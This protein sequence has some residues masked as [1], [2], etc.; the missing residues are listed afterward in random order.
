MP[1]S[2]RTRPMSRAERRLWRQIRAR[3]GRT[4]PGMQ[5]AIELSFDNIRDI[6]TESEIIRLLDSTRSDA[7]ITSLV[8]EL[9]A[10][11]AFDPTRVRLLADVQAATNA[12][13]LDLPGGGRVSGQSIAAF[14][15]LND[16]TREAVRQLDS[17]VMRSLIDELRE[18]MREAA[19]IGLERGEGSRTIARRVRRSIGLAPNQ[20]GHIE[21]FRAKLLTGDFKGAFS[22][23]LRDKRFDRTL[24]R[25][26]SEGGRLSP[27]QVNKMTAAYTRKWLRHNSEVHARTAMNDAQRLGRHLATVGAIENGILPAGRMF[28][29]WSSSGDSR[30]RQ[31]HDDPPTGVH[32]QVVRFGTPFA[33]GDVVPG[34]SEWGCRCIKVDFIHP[35][36]PVTEPPT[37]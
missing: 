19:R 34:A 5:R 32:G 9:E 11:R 1:E 20:L 35:G 7:F 37:L 6:L 13:M 23:R 31:T 28:S 12:F 18:T 21:R 17:R 27:D 26:I 8:D 4:T 22:N 14:N 36:N 30:V 15:L 3:V 24:R 25:L 29:R 16:R 10:N 2:W 33:T